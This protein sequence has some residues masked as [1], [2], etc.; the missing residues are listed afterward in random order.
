MQIM[1]QMVLCKHLAMLRVVAADVFLRSFRPQHS[2]TLGWLMYIG[3][4]S[5][6]AQVLS[7]TG[8]SARNALSSPEQIRQ[9]AS[10]GP[11]CGMA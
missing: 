8:L 5:V 10:T 6:L 7:R 3:F 1:L 4:V 11:C 9:D 2:T